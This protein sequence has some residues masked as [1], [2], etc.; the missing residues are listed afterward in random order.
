MYEILITSL[1][2]SIVVQFIY[3]TFWEGMILGRVAGWLIDNLPKWMHKPLFDCPICMT[4]WYS[5]VIIAILQWVDYLNYPIGVD[6]LIIFVAS[7]WST[8]ISRIYD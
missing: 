3:A 4:P 1:V 8:I 2:Y 5:L 7:G 6:V